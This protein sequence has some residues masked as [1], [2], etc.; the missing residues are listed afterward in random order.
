MINVKMRFKEPVTFLL[1]A[2]IP[3]IFIKGQP[4]TPPGIGLTPPAKINYTSI[5]DQYNSSTCWSFSSNSF[6]ESE[7]I[8]KGKGKLDLSEMFV[9]RY[10]YLRKIKTH[11]RRK[12]GNY[13]LA[14]GQFHDVAWV[15]KNY[16]MMP[17]ELYT[18]KVHG[19]LVY[20]HT[21]LDT[22]MSYFVRSILA[23]GV[24]EL[25]KMQLAYADSLLDAYLGK[26]PYDFNYKGKKYTPKTFLHDY[27]NIDPDDYVE[28]TS[29]THH[30]YYTLFILED[31]Y[32]WTSDYYYNVPINDFTAITNA[33][34]KAGYT[35]GWDGDAEEKGFDFQNGLAYMDYKINDY[36][37]E[38]QS[39]LDDKSTA[40]NHMMHIVGLTSDKFGK[41][42][43]YIKNSWGTNN[44]LLNGFLYMSEDYFKI[45]TGAII[46][47]RNAIPLPLKKRMG[48]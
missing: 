35:V 41:S 25:T 14:G 5:K 3:F 42:W 34:L 48:I 31:K 36:Q 22:A 2:L 45:K 39:T 19:E 10:S 15:M 18:G 23:T 27:L 44:N 13:F 43:Y 20:D 11:L 46:V 28:I 26:V 8:K 6:I 33:A 16:G 37:Q 30:P 38:R 29:Y 9:V 17:A 1:L 7:L 47:N 40:I 24:T 4:L 12:G 21:D 32:N